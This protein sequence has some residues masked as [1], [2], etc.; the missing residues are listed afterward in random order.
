M[1]EGAAYDFR[2]PSKVQMLGQLA[3][4]FFFV[5]GDAKRDER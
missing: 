1:I 2:L 5:S 3:Q 4:Q